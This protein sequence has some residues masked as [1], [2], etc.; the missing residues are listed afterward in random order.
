VLTSRVSFLDDSPQARA[1]LD[2]T[3]L[4]SQRLAQQ[5]HARGIDPLRLPRFSVLRLRDDP[6]AGSFLARQL[7]H[8]APRAAA[9]S[10][11]GLADLLWAHL[12][13]VAGPGLLPPWPIA[14]A[15]RS[16]AASPCSP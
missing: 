6:A 3:G 1:L 7:R 16:C 4:L 8:L 14:S 12:S 15:W 5:L 2:G 10:P 13:T 9:A 11:A